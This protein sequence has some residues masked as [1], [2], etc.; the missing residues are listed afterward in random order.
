MRITTHSTGEGDWESPTRKVIGGD[1]QRPDATSSRKP[2]VQRAEYPP[3]GRLVKDLTT[4]PTWALP[5]SDLKQSDDGRTAR[6]QTPTTTT[7]FYNNVS[8]FHNGKQAIA[9]YSFFTLTC[10]K[11]LIVGPPLRLRRDGLF[12]WKP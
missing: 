8:S 1:K 3:A 4:L 11:E 12:I 10:K 7:M 5:S 6:H 9:S 2:R